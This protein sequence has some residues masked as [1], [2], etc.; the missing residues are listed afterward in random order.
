MKKTTKQEE[1]SLNDYLDDNEELLSSQIAS[2]RSAVKRAGADTSRI[3]V[4]DIKEK[5]IVASTR[6]GIIRLDRRTL[7]KSNDAELVHRLQHEQ[8]H[9]DG[10]YNEGLIELM[11]AQ[12][13][14]TGRNFYKREQARVK[15][16]TDILSPTD[17]IKRAERMYKQKKIKLLY[18]T[19]LIAAARKNIKQKDAHRMF[20][21][22]FPEL[23][24]HIRPRSSKSDPLGNIKKDIDR[25]AA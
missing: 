25:K 1:V 20:I 9:V 22:A 3:F 18:R 19:F 6:R 12:H 15:K 8:T 23:E 13:N 17:G 11:I 2:V 4:T 21:D 10:I 14:N 7:K 16:I 5:D 24:K